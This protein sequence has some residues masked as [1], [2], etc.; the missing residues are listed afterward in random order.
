MVTDGY[1][2]FYNFEPH[3]TWV[4]TTNFRRSFVTSAE[5]FDS[6]LENAFADMRDVLAS[7]EMSKI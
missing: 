2:V 7:G 4:W 5:K 6:S 1:G 3:Q